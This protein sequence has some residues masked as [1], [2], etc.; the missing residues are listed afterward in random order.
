MRFLMK[1]SIFLAT[2][3]SCLCFG[4]LFQATKQTQFEPVHASSTYDH[5]GTIDDPFT[6]KDALTKCAETGTVASPEF[7][8]RGI[9]CHINEIQTTGFYLNATYFISD[10]GSRNNELEVYRGFYIDGAGWSDETAKELTVGKVVTVQGSLI[11]YKGN[12]KEFTTG[13]KVISIAEQH[14]K[15]F[16]VNVDVQTVMKVDDLFEIR[17]S[18][19]EYTRDQIDDVNY[20]ISDS[21]IVEVRYNQTIPAY[22]DYNGNYHHGVTLN[23]DTMYGYDALKALS[24]GSVMLTIEV[25]TKEGQKGYGYEVVTVYQALDSLETNEIGQNLPEGGQTEE[26]YFFEGTIYFYNYGGNII[27]L[28]YGYQTAYWNRDYINV[29]FGSSN[30]ALYRDIISRYQTVCGNDIYLTCTIQNYYGE[31]RLN[32]PNLVG[33]TALELVNN[34]YH[35]EETAATFLCLTSGL[36]SYWSGGLY[37]HGYV[38]RETIVE[39]YEQVFSSFTHTNYWGLLDSSIKNYYKTEDAD[40][41]MNSANRANQTVGE[42]L[43]RYDYIVAKYGVTNFIGREITPLPINARFSPNDFSKNETII[44]IVIV[45][46]IS[47]VSLLTLLIVKKRRSIN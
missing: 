40:A 1:K 38:E 10:D 33:M 42:F 17:S 41:L 7:V 2:I 25:I 6:V 4:L 27:H 20:Y 30:E 45:T 44:S 16:D 21:T 47:L 31:I 12:T 11:N 43:K 5:A 14:E 36:C 8:A 19:E 18:Q 46:S 3:L 28:K 23:T 37:E 29:Y 24:K 13:S 22:Y 9:V 39:D 35:P 26:R 34:H 15:D 32:N